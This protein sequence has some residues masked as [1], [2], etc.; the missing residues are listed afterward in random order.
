MLRSTGSKKIRKSRGKKDGI[1]LFNVWK[2]TV[3]GEESEDKN[4]ESAQLCLLNSKGIERTKKGKSSVKIH[5]K[6]KLLTEELEE[7]SNIEHNSRNR[8]DASQQEENKIRSHGSRDEKDPVD[9]AKPSE[10]KERSLTLQSPGKQ[11]CEQSYFFNLSYKLLSEF[12]LGYL[13]FV[14]FRESLC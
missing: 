1:D 2:R 9:Q 10:D 8:S 12:Y 4:E 14:I 3:F 6:F 7:I 5:K 11:K 13:Y